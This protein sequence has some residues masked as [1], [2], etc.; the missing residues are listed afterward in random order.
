MGQ[1]RRVGDIEL[2]EDDAF[3]RREWAVQRAGWAV[4]SLFVLAALA[5]AFGH[6]PL[7][8]A[9]AT[10]GTVQVRYERFV[11]WETPT[12]LE[13][14]AGA[15]GSF[16]LG[17]AYLAR[18]RVEEIHPEPKAQQPV[19]GGVRYTFDGAPAVVRFTV[20]PQRMGRLHGRLVAPGGAT[21]TLRQF[22][23]P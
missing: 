21:T 23:Y 12:T 4:L 1:V 14:T 3:Q 16:V 6:G 7:S 15:P 2:D 13:V 19:P 22:V 5:G 20:E 9:E 17:A 10:A 18:V 11:R 8:S